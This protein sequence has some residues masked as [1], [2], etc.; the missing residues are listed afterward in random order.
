MQ[1]RHEKGVEMINSH[2]VNAPYMAQ[3]VM[4]IFFEVRNSWGWSSGI[5]SVP[6]LARRRFETACNDFFLF[7]LASIAEI[8]T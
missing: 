1:F 8:P 4:L 3:L 6:P 5:V 2:P 7:A